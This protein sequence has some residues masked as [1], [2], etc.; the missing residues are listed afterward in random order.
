MSDCVFC[1][2]VAGEVP[3]YQV[4]EDD[5]H[6]A[7]LTPWPNTEGFTVVITKAHHPSY[8]FDLP[9][10]V[11]TKLIEASATVAQKIDAA[12]LDVGRT[13]LIF[14]GFGV[15]HIHAKLVPMHGTAMP[16]WK[17]IGS[18]DRTYY[19]QY[20]GFI[21]SHDGPEQSSDQLAATAEKI[22]NA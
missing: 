10:D 21:A 5:E 6:L 11:R 18:T 3:S 12:F 14:E 2:I 22:R 19:D 8:V 20:P 16:E 13:G 4:W 1:K 15:N 9:T 17:P 7:F